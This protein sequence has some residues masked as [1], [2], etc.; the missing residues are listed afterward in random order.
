M[1]R[2]NLNGEIATELNKIY[3]QLARSQ[4]PFES[5]TTRSGVQ[6]WLERTSEP[7]IGKNKLKAG[8][9]KDAMK[10][11]DRAR[12]GIGEAK[13]MIHQ[14]WEKHSERVEAQNE[15]GP[16]EIQSGTEETS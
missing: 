12:E 9:A 11:M 13:I 14:L 4:K 16:S 8:G 2:S 6:D 5:Y 7:A 10:Q 1:S 3:D 15:I